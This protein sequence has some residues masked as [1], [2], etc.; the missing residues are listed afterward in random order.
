MT[1]SGFPYPRKRFGQNFLIDQNIVRK[2][3]KRAALCP[4]EVVLEIGPGRGVLT[5]PLCQVASRVLAIEIDTELFDYLQ[6]ALKQH[7]NLEMHLGDALVYPYE[8]LPP[9]T[10]VVANL[11]YNISTPLLFKL[12]EARASIDRMILMVQLEVA[13][14]IV[15]KTGT[16]EYGVLSVI[17]QYFAD[18]DLAFKVPRTCFRPSPDV[19]SAIIEIRFK[20]LTALGLQE[21]I[22]KFIR[23]VKTAFRHRRKT[24]F[25][26][27]RD[28]ELAV[29]TIELAFDRTGI[30][31]RRRAETLTV[32]DFQRLAQTISFS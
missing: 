12:F 26:A 4:E 8:R 21:D 15:G 24:L 31:G 28:A 19:E 32:Q 13:K 6:Q 16:R 9:N 14:R 30:N 10:V 17:A 5:G 1:P 23:V 27:M 3:V 11:P 25:N 29:D 18:V 22:E 2:I 20:P 7:P